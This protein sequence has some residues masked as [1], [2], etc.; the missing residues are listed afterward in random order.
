MTVYLTRTRARQ[1][2]GDGWGIMMHDKFLNNHRDHLG[3]RC[4]ASVWWSWL[5][6]SALVS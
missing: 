6:P 2:T 1:V 4:V 5:R 3:Y